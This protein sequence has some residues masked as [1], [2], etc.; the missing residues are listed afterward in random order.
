LA[1]SNHYDVIVVGAGPAGT[2]AAWELARS[3]RRVALI[4]KQTLPRHKTCGGGMPMVVAQLLELDTL[5]DLAP[6]AFVECDTRYLRHTWN[7]H[8]ACLAPMNPEAADAET[9]TPTPPTR[10]LWMVRRSV[11][12]NALARR[13]EAAGAELRDG[14]AIRAIE[15]DGNRVT[16]RAGTDA[17]TWSATCDTLIGADGANGV[18]ARSVGLRRERMLAI[19]IEAEVPHRWGDG[20]P[21]LRRDVAH[22]EYGVV[23]RGYAW[24]FPKGDHLN[25]GAGVFRPRR[26]DGRGD[27][28]VRDELQRA[29]VGYL[30]MLGVPRR[31]EDLTFHAHPLPIWNGLDRLQSRDNRVLLVGDAAGLI[32]PLFGDGILHALRSGKIAAECVLEGGTN[33]YTEA[34][35]AEFK[36]NFDAA[37][38]MAKF[39]YQWSGFCYRHGV[40]QPGATRTAVRLLSGEAVFTDVVGRALKRLQK[41][42]W[43]NRAV[44]Q[45]TEDLE[46]VK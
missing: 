12:D 27:N 24:V 11:F 25:V 46:I 13:A 31:A 42:M 28:T 10:S 36:A 20:H 7:W 29:I 30:E 33:T 38:T 18:T 32:N 5:R 17:A 41:E 2:T 15:T 37:L 34:I 44:E 45:N 35:G 21:D 16:V 9:G 43:P 1:L 19:A 14:L 3:G 8:D 6:E 23:K 26:S 22:L 39:F 4:E 40:V